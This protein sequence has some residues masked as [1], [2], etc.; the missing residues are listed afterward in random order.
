M[1]KIKSYLYCVSLLSFITPAFAGYETLAVTIEKTSDP[2]QETEIIS[3]PEGSIAKI[4]NAHLSDNY[5]YHG[6]LVLTVGGVTA[7]IGIDSELDES[8]FAGPCTIKIRIKASGAVQ[9]SEGG[10]AVVNFHVYLANQNLVEPSSAV[11]IPTETKGTVE[12]ILESSQD[13]ITWTAAT[14]GSY[15]SDS[16]S[17]FFRVRAIAK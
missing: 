15:S 13:M 3:I 5:T 16:L 2:A 7:N 10:S 17:R 9:S 6:Y 14:P 8:V 11:V 1:N 4:T 12:I